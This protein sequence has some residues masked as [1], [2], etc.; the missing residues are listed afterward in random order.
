MALLAGMIGSDARSESQGW[1]AFVYPQIY[2]RMGLS[3]LVGT[4][5]A[6]LFNHLWTPTGLSRSS[7]QFSI[8]QLGLLMAAG[9]PAG[10]LMWNW[11][12]VFAMIFIQQTAFVTLL[13]LNAP[14]RIN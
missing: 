7:R 9:G 5:I 1:S 10:W 8:R 4:W 14:P 12:E 13:Y 3:S 11:P 6:L 2:A